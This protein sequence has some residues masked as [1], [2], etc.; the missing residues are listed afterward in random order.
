[1]QLIS[2]EG[3]VPCTQISPEQLKTVTSILA[4]K[5]IKLLA[6]NESG[7]H[8]SAIARTLHEHE[9]KIYYH[10][11]KLLK[12]NIIVI[13]RTEDA[14]GGTAKIL[15]LKTPAYAVR[16][17]K[18]E[19]I[20]K[21]ST[22]TTEQEAYL[23][24]F[25]ENGHLNCKIIVGSPDPH[26]PEHARS[27]DT[28]YAI[29]LA[30]FLGTFLTTPA[31]PI[32]QLDTELRDW[33]NNLIIIGGPVVNK[34]AERIN[35]QSPIPYDRSKKAFIIGKKKFDHE[36]TGVIIKM[37]NPYAKGKYILH[38]MGKRYTG[39]RAAILALMKNFDQLCKQSGQKTH[40][41]IVLGKDDDSDGIIDNAQIIHQT[42][43]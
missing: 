1:M 40:I 23:T 29:D 7:L 30:L 37:K 19:P 43:T 11:R 16:F 36:E 10:A 42:L 39:T 22:I 28:M 26:G 15:K 5:I 2:A 4:G 8:S 6:E 3:Q 20:T 35:R 31:T 27:R 24:P 25:I 14:Q 12:A 17:R 34:A 33:N 32:M 21:I 41:S 38:I 9:Q 18:F 13:D